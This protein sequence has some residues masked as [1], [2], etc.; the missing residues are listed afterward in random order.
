MVIGN[1]FVGG[2]IMNFK[3]SFFNLVCQTKIMNVKA[4]GAFSGT[5]LTVFQHANVEN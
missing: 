4:M 3:V 2:T 1:H 5:V